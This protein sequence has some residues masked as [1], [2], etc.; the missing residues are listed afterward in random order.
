[1]LSVSDHV[2]KQPPKCAPGDR[3]VGRVESL[4]TLIMSNV[5]DDDSEDDLDWEEVDVPDHHE[6][7]LEITLQAAP[8]KEGPKHKGTSHA[9]RV[10][11]IDCH[12]IH[13]V[14]LLLNASVRNRWIND[15]LLHVPSISPPQ[16][17]I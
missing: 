1:M 7:H 2:R 5:A 10:A 15:P 9:D 3:H 11:R 13:T 17:P 8:K 6:R 16:M 4:T 14:A 12:K